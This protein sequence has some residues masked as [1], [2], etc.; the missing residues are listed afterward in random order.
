MSQRLNVQRDSR[1][2][3]FMLSI[4]YNAQSSC[5]L[6]EQSAWHPYDVRG[7]GG[8]AGERVQ[9]RYDR[10]GD[11]C[12]RSYGVR[13][14]LPFR[15]YCNWVTA[16][17]PCEITECRLLMTRPRL[18]DKLTVVLTH[19]VEPFP[20]PPILARPIQPSDSPYLSSLEP[21]N[22]HYPY[23]SMCTL[24]SPIHEFSDRNG[25]QHLRGLCPSPSGEG[26][27]AAHTFP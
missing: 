27:A 22:H 25:S 17:V 26:Y 6:Q 10:P 9:A 4:R 15:G 11:Q 14:D 3:L 23:A 1:L 16:V 7:E 24:F 19:D 12:A 13:C 2:Y 18:S 20:L 5:Q 21:Y 8:A